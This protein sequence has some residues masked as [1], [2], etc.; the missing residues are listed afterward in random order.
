M[1][2]GLMA[3]LGV[4]SA[5]G[6]AVPAHADP[7]VDASFTDA[8]HKAGITFT[9]SKTAVSAGKTACDLMDKGNSEIDVIALVMQQN[10]GISNI[11]AAKFTAIAASAYCPQHLQLP[12]G[13]SPSPTPPN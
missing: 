5:L 2:R 11:S 9:D 4:A 1:M 13:A 6:L 10:T 3:V 8:L 7:G 12:N